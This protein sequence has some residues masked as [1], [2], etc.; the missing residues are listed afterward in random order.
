MPRITARESRVAR[1]TK[2]KRGKENGKK[3]RA[4]FVSAAADLTI[5]VRTRAPESGINDETPF[6]VL[7]RIARPV[8]PF[9][10]SVTG[11]M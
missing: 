1:F 2:K 5:A 6:F 7:R 8:Y 11:N 9:F 10:A 4:S 3:K